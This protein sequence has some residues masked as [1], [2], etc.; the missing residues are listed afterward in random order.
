MRI[1][2]YIYWT[3]QKIRKKIT[4]IKQRLYLVTLNPHRE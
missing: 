3:V 1:A 2:I 4:E